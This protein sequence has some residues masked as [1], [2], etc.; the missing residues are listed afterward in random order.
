VIAAIIAVLAIIVG[1]YAS[2]RD[3]N[4][5]IMGV[6]G[7]NPNM[8]EV[9]IKSDG[10]WSADI[11]DSE[12]RSHS[13]DGFGDRKI[14]LTC[15]SDGKYSLTVQRSDGRSGTLNVEVVKNGSSS[16]SQRS[17][18]TSANGIISLSGTC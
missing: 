5:Q 7:K 17:T 13:L 10:G 18:T 2:E 4:N 14:Q 3:N 12:F 8:V 15:S 9:V 16:S 6:G 11:K 1:L